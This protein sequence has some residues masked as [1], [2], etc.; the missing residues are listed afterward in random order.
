MPCLK[1]GTSPPCRQV[2][3]LV[4]FGGKADIGGSGQNVAFDPKR[5]QQPIFAA[6]HSEGVMVLKCGKPRPV[7]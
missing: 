2:A 3:D 1:I 7:R 4:A 5:H 6:M